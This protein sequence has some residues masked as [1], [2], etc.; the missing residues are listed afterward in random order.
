M[1]TV[2]VA[3]EELRSG[4][5]A[6]NTHQTEDPSTYTSCGNIPTEDEAVTIALEAQND[7]GQSGYATLID[8]GETTDVVVDLSVGELSSELIH[9]HSGSCDELG[10]VEYDLLSFEGGSGSSI[11]SLDVAMSEILASQH[12]INA[13]EVGDPSNYT[14]CGTL[15]VME[16]APGTPT[17]EATPTA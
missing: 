6:I 1:T 2:D 11:T 16:P 13:H 4:D 15:P 12:A 9:I 17:V 10:G 5:F 14:A 3:L 7:S 8:D